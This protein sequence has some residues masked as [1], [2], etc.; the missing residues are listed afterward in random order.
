MPG[1]VMKPELLPGRG[2][3]VLPGAVSGVVADRA[4]EMTSLPLPAGAVPSP[5][6]GRAEPPWFAYE[7]TA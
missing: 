7:A 4:S 3:G 2:A 1:W 6:T 5:V